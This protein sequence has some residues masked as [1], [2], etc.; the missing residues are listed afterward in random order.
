MAAATTTGLVQSRSGHLQ[1]RRGESNDDDPLDAIGRDCVGP[2]YI[3]TRVQ[4][5]G[6]F[7]SKFF[8]EK[9]GN[10]INRHNVYNYLIVTHSTI[11]RYSYTH[12]IYSI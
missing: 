11:A 7:E 10:N 1:N 4:Y 6:I 8:R 3:M 5:V 2:T 12:I 9:I